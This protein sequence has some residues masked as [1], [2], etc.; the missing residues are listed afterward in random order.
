MSQGKRRPDTLRRNSLRHILI[1]TCLMLLIMLAAGPQAVSQ[2]GEGSQPLYTGS[3]PAQAA[4]SEWHYTLT[5]RVR[6]LLFWIS[7]ENVGGAHIAW[8]EG[9]DGSRIAELLIGSDPTRAPMRINRWGYISERAAGPTAEI[10]GVMTTS[11]EES[12]DQAKRGLTRQRDAH[13]FKAIRSSLKDG[14]ASSTVIHLLLADDFTYKDVEGLLRQL[15]QAGETTRQ[16]S[17]SAD[18]E[19]GF[20]LAVKALLHEI[21]DSYNRLGRVSGQRLRRSFVY[22][23]CLYELSQE[24]AHFQ[25][26]T[27]AGGRVYQATIEIRLRTRNTATGETAGFVITCGTRTPFAEAPIRIVYRPRWWFETELLLQ[28]CSE[29]LAV[30]GTTRWT[31]F[32]R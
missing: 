12:I 27:L 16:K 18:V 10:L 3:T 20:L 15:P 21:V 14:V 30:A 7:R 2:A 5:A 24:G 28:D 4:T 17:V 31:R 22:N 1:A 11:D 13:A 6:P 29:V 9:A 25:P 26:E 19:P 23:S 32:S 8:T